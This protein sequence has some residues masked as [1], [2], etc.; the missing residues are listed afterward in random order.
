MEDVAQS[1]LEVAP[2]RGPEVVPQ[3]DE[4]NY[5]ISSS[6]PSE[7]SL[8]RP[9]RVINTS[10]K[11][12]RNKALWALAVIGFVCLAAALGAGLGVGRADKHVSIASS[13]A[14]TIGLSNTQIR[15]TQASAITTTV[16][17]SFPTTIPSSLVCPTADKA[18]YT[19]TNKPPGNMYSTFL[20]PDT[21]LTYQILCDTNFLAEL[22]ETGAV[23]LQI[24]K[25]VTL[26]KDCL[27]AS[28]LYIFQTPATTFPHL[29]RTGLVW[30][31]DLLV[32]KTSKT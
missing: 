16:P 11:I 4:A 18:N 25:N 23:D 17:Y 22:G 1:G 6:Q 15:T 31:P 20:I 8:G 9:H 29:G 28:A 19:A 27:D 7:T 12:Q 21:S 14:R 10:S 2:H 5:F 30:D 26:F 32:M 3:S 13:T 24:I